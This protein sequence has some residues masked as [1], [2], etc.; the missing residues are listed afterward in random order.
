M[1]KQTAKF[2]VDP[3]TLYERSRQRQESFREAE[4]TASEISDNS[5]LDEYEGAL[6]QMDSLPESKLAKRIT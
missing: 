1:S 2:V 4:L 5:E 6:V 3:K